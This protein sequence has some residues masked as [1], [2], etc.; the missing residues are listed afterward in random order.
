MFP[1]ELFESEVYLEML[2]DGERMLPPKLL[3]E[4]GNGRKVPC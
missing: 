3:E 2:D 1:Q 4:E